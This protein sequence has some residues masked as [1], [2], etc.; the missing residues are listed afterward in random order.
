MKNEL[1]KVIKLLMDKPS[2]L[3]IMP[4]EN[5]VFANNLS[6]LIENQRGFKNVNLK[7]ALD[8]FSEGIVLAKN[9]N[10]LSAKLNLDEGFE[11]IGAMKYKLPKNYA[12]TF[13][14]ASLSYWH[15]RMNEYDTAEEKLW[16]AI[17][18]DSF[19]C[20]QG[21]EIFT[22][23]QIQQLQNIVRIYFKKGD[24]ENAC[25]LVNKTLSFLLLGESVRFNENIEY[26]KIS[27]DLKDDMVWQLT[28]ETIN[29]IQSQ[30]LNKFQ[31]Y[32]KIAFKN[33]TN[34]D[35]STYHEKLHFQ[36]FTLKELYYDG[37]YF[38]FLTMLPDFIRDTDKNY[39]VYMKNIFF[40]IKELHYKLM[41]EAA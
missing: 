10:L 30:R 15:Y 33:L 26:A 20:E 41:A 28:S 31:E 23:H 7:I 39:T 40:D 19:L 36:W 27:K 12:F 8:K 35:S 22:M 11:I 18:V 4:F 25:V 21:F 3:S 38:D 34:F 2:D 17:R 14:L 29:L 16:N 13:G 9:N 37:K 32:Y 24:F 5:N 6:K 1:A